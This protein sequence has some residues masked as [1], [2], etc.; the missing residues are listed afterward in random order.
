MSNT[1]LDLESVKII[2]DSKVVLD[3]VNLKIDTGEIVSL[4]GSSASGK[5]SLIRSIAG[6]HNITSGVIKIDNQVIDDSNKYIDVAKRNV[7]VIFQ[8][9]ALF[10]HLTVRENIYFGLNALD[11]V[12]KRK[13]A[14]KLENLLSIENI[15]NKYP[16]QISGGQQ[17]RVAIA[18][19]IAPKPNLLLL[20][21]PFAGIDPIAIEEVKSTISLLKKM[22]IGIIVTDHNVKEA[23]S[24]VDFGYIIYNGEIIKSGSPK[25][26]TSD[27]FVK[28]I[29]LG[30]NYT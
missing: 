13:R 8:D 15:V 20:D 24:I 7:G 5:T 11:N 3:N 21:E 28:K 2:L 12:Q 29:Y 14:E 9:L 19:A 30:K 23:L 25:E 17:Q 26:I 16:N 22:N 6:F 18:R 10:P 4:M 1:K 27:K